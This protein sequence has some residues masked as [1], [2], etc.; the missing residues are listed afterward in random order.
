MPVR[1][2][3]IPGLT[4]PP[5]ECNDPL[6]PW[7][8]KLPIRGRILKC[9]VVS[10]KMTKT[11]TVLHEYLHYVPKY[12]RYER[13]RKKIHAHLPPCIDVRPGDIVIIGECRPL[14]KT[15]SFTV[16]AKESPKGEGG[17]E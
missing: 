1:N 4:P 6:C 9:K 17:G 14:A 12:K 13:R 2:I 8:G 10:N 11:V 16:L 7:H 15:V 5:K 3:G